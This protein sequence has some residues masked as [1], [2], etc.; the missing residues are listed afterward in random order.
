MYSL[1]CC[2]AK[3]R[4]QAA[5]QP[6]DQ[7]DRVFRHLIG[8]HAGRTGDDDV[9]TRRRWAPANDPG[10]PPTTESISAVPACTT[11]SQST[12]TFGWP[13]NMSQLNSSSA[14]SFL[15]GVAD[16]RL[17]RGGLNLSDVP[18]FDGIAENDSHGHPI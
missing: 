12:G 9:A 18:R 6:R 14:T 13:Q 7:G 4:R 1:V 11:P 10:P 15:P 8:Q 16:F 2:A 17:R 3:K 5:Q